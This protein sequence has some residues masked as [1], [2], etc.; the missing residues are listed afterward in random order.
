[1]QLHRTLH[2][3]YACFKRVSGWREQHRATGQGPPASARRPALQPGLELA[4]EYGP[5][6]GAWHRS[7]QV[8][9]RILGATRVDATTIEL[10]RGAV[11]TTLPD[12]THLAVLTIRE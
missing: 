4:C 9:A 3:A 2:I 12:G 11:L 5:A 1:V 10:A 8:T 7:G 6:T